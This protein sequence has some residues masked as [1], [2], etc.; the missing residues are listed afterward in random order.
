MFWRL[1]VGERFDDVKG[2]EAKRRFRALVKKGA[3]RGFVAF[4]GDEAVG[5]LSAGRRAEFAKLNRAPSL[6]CDDADQVHSLPCFFV[7][8]GARGTGV[9]T[10][11]LKTA[12][13]TLARQGATVIE[14][15]PVLPPRA[16]E[17]IPAAFAYTGTLPLFEQAGFEVVAARPK[18]K[19]RVRKVLG[20]TRAGSKV[21]SGRG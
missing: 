6:K 12:V 5:W 11:L 3:A 13:R 8:P 1:E 9:A 17:P 16:G 18:G 2:A 14:G 15:Y 7:K 21:G 4:D 10:A 20:R 19:Q